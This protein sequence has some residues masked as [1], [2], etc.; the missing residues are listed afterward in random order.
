MCFWLVVCFPV[1]MVNDAL[2]PC[3][4]AFAVAFEFLCHAHMVFDGHMAWC[5]A[6]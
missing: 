6:A 3:V 5:C 4:Y 1:H 2:M